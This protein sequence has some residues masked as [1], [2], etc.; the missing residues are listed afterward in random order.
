M[1]VLHSYMSERYTDAASARGSRADSRVSAASSVW[2]E[3]QAGTGS[4]DEELLES[5]EVACRWGAGGCVVA[6]DLARVDGDGQPVGAYGD[7]GLAA[8]VV[9]DLR[10][11]DAVRELVA[12][13]PVI[14]V[15]GDDLWFLVGV[16]GDHLDLDDAQ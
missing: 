14:R 10:A 16:G 15:K 4:E 13:G 9:G 7:D 1:G 3:C 6:P 11:R 5:R 12:W 8:L 2:G